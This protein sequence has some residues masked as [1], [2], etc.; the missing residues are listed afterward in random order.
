MISTCV[1]LYIMPATI[2]LH[3]SKQHTSTR[4]LQLDIHVLKMK[5]EYISMNEPDLAFQKQ[6]TEKYQSTSITSRLILQYYSLFIICAFLL[7]FTLFYSVTCYYVATS[8][9][10]AVIPLLV[11]SCDHITLICSYHE[12]FSQAWYL[13]SALSLLCIVINLINYFKIF[14]ATINSQH[15]LFAFLLTLILYL[16][17]TFA[18]LCY[19]YYF[20][21]SMYFLCKL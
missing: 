13:C 15:R 8:F 17:P 19:N 4:T 7:T 9:V 18:F 5:T 2:Y 6:F 12:I 20:S 1:V 3:N 10:S 16:V 14:P 11:F 21:L